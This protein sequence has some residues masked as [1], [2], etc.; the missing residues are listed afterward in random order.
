VA[1]TGWTFAVVGGMHMRDALRLLR[2]YQMAPPA[3]VSMAVLAGLYKP[4]SK[5]TTTTD[6]DSWLASLPT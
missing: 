5:R 2:H 1:A 3:Y 6:V 4:P